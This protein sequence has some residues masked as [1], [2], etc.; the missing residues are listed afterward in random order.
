VSYRS[1]EAKRRKRASIRATKDEYRQRMESRYYLT[2]VKREC[3][4]SACGMKLRFGTDLVYRKLGPVTLC[5]RCADRDPLV[6]YR[7]SLRWE[8]ARAP[9]RRAA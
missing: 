5:L 1:R 3:R 9:E 4:C 8:K 6:D 7:P 2:K